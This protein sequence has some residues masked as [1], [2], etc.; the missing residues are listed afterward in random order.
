[1]KNIK[2]YNLDE[3]QEELINLGEKKFRAEQI[4]KWLYVE[5]VKSF[6]DMTNLSLELRE[7]LK[8]NYTMCNYN[9]IKKQESSDGTKKYLFDVLDGNAI[10][11][12]LM[13]YH[14]GKTV[15]VSSQIGCKMGCKFCASTGVKFIRSLT[16][17]E[18]VEQILAVEQDIN[19]RIS[20]I[21]FMGI[22]EPLDNYDNVIKAIKILNNQKG[23][24]IGTRHISVSTSGIVPRIY[25]LANENIQCTLSI[26][27]H[28]TTD[29][30][31]SSMMPINNRYNIQELMKACKDYIKITNK[32][33]S[34]EY[35]LAKDNND[36][37]DDAKQLVK[38]LKGM[39]CHVNLI[40]IN[41]IENG[42]FSKSTNEN[43]LKF[44]D[45]LNENGIVAT[46]RRELGSDID[47]ACGQL[48]RK[49]LKE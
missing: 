35:A 40:P 39:L 5:K 1:M 8:Q 46:I 3:L 25:D 29:E 26:S 2:D 16:A 34:F 12:V 38:L 43:I 49:N 41:K 27:L 36:N 42:K 28:A 21:V 10:E 15:C 23:L 13:Q 33:I 32:R 17:G 4:F 6:D 11:T 31:R 24:S 22:G 48:R 19:D 30:K 47:A 20:N 9:I 44:R 37:L 7:K 45:F 14:H 18:I